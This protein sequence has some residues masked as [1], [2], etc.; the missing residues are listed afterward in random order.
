MALIVSSLVNV[1]LFFRCFEIGYFESFVPGREPHSAP[2][3][4]GY[5]APT[6]QEAPVEMLFALLTTAL[7][8]LVLGLL[9]G[10]IVTRVIHQAL[11]P[12]LG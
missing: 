6:V 1:V 9:S 10:Q 5:D 2:V 4:P 7:L 3:E 8:L 12:V 11:P